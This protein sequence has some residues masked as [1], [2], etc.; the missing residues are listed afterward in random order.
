MENGLVK[1]NVDG[2]GGLAHSCLRNIC[3]VF[4]VAYLCVDTSARIL[5][6]DLIFYYSQI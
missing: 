1:Q 6:C 4:T 5:A 3:Y 2:D